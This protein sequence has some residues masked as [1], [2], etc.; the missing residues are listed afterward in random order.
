MSDPNPDPTYEEAT[1]TAAELFEEFVDTMAAQGYIVEVASRATW[2]RSAGP[3]ATSGAR[4][5]QR[6]RCPQS[7]G[8]VLRYQW[9][10]DQCQPQVDCGLMLGLLA[11]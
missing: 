6:L 2:P 11:F 5:R 4:T 8:R 3:P 9:N 1:A 7:R 10:H